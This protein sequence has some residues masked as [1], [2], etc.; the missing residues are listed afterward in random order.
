MSTSIY[1]RKLHL[2]SFIIK[3]RMIIILIL[4]KEFVGVAK[5][6][7]IRL[8]NTPVSDDLKLRVWMD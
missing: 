5:K 7:E 3:I 8:L 2:K 6:L 1:F 4:S